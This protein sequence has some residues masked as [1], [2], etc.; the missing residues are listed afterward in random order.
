MEKAKRKGHPQSFWQYFVDEYIL[1]R[2]DFS[3]TLEVSPE[4]LAEKLDT[5]DY[6]NPSFW[7]RE[8]RIQ[9]RVIQSREQWHFEMIAEQPVQNRRNL[10]SQRYTQSARAEGQI[11]RDDNGKTLLEGTVIVG[12]WQ[13]WL[14][15]ILSAVV[16]FAFFSMR[17]FGDFS[18]GYFS[19]FGF[20]YI[21]VIA[22]S[23]FQSYQD[24]NHLV[25]LVEE[26]VES[27]N[28]RIYG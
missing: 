28:E 11:Y 16:F 17:G 6:E 18:G 21:G 5:L 26:A 10:F 19:W 23:W 12:G 13:Y 20:I 14:G 9:A 2:R 7:V 8:R 3:Y 24:R 1:F 22:Y 25:K 27:A 4:I 15:V